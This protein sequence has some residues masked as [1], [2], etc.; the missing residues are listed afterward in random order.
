ME[1]KR[2]IEL[3]FGRDEA[4]I[5]ESGKKY[6]KYLRYIAFSVLG[7]ESDCEEVENDTYLRA[8]NSIP[9]ERPVSLKGYLASL[10]RNLA[11]NRR[12]AR[13]TLKRGEPDLVLD[14]L[15]E[16]L[17]DPSSDDPAESFTLREAIEAFLRSLEKRDRVIF[18]QRYFYNCPIA[19]I[20]KLHGMKESA[21]TMLLFR[22]RLKL[23]DKLTK[24]EINL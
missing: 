4:A 23:K 24:E 13:K 5:V 22:T 16:C 18:L 7:D 6:G 9:P 8:W 11:L 15:A 1:D 3:F 14:E 19:R 2:I 20:A 21:V 12:K 10:C 17:P